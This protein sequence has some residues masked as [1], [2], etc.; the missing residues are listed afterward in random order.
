MS[1]LEEIG[2]QFLILVS[3]KS[4]E[5]PHKFRMGQA[6]QELHLLPNKYSASGKARVLA[7]AVPR[8]Q[9]LVT[10][11]QEQSFCTPTH[12]FLNTALS[13]LCFPVSLDWPCMHMHIYVFS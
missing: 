9:A 5:D 12:P 8:A 2:L 13:L 1:Y 11:V 10:R 4:C 6:S 7:D 3:W